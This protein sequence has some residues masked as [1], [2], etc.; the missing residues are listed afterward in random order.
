[1]QE[2]TGDV[3]SLAKSLPA[4]A[5]CIPT[6]LVVK[7]DGKAVMGKGMALD[8]LH[9]FPGIDTQLGNYLNYWGKQY[10]IF[11]ILP[12]WHPSYQGYRLYSFPTKGHF[13]KPSNIQLI[14]AAAIELEK[15]V[16]MRKLKTIL[17]PRV[18]CGLGGLKWDGVKPVLEKYLD[19]RFMVVS[20]G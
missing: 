17:L 3:W 1:M 14:E 2:L 19:G 8:A 6:N 16:T 10:M 7:G 15:D 5:V 4:D 20:R 11:D 9:R 12:R 18:G 13:S